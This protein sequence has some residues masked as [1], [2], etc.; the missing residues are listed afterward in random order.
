MTPIPKVKK[1]LFVVDRADLD[2]QTAKE[3]NYFQPDSVD[4][5]T[6]TKSLVKQF[7][8]PNVKLIITTIQKLNKEVVLVFRP[9]CSLVKMD[10]G[11]I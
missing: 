4:Q 9:V 2:H 7:T 3:Y 11:F 8:N 5:T 10:Q 1:T 6:D